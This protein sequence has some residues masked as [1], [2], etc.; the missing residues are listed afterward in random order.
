LT[1]FSILF[2]VAVWMG[3][4]HLFFKEGTMRRSYFV[5]LAVFATVGFSQARADFVPWSYNWEPSSLTIKAGGAGTGG[6]AL[7]DE[8]LKHADG[9]S[10]VVVTNIRA[11][12]SATR[13]NPDVLTHA[14]FSFKLVLRDEKSNQTAVL[15]FG[16]FFDG[17]ISATSAN[18]KATFTAPLF[19]T[20]KLGGHTFTI[21]LGNFAPPGPPAASNAGSIS[22]NV[23]VDQ[24]TSGGGTGG[25]TGGG[26]APEPSTLLLSCLGLSSLGLGG[27][28]KW[29]QKV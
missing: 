7:T 13:N 2:N 22:A 14:A 20:V 12:S 26:H 4:H 3:R 9:T 8:P 18:V 25:G 21:N 17:T 19:Q 27:W 6:L 11:F 10:D 28:R 16:G 15:S 23:A 5:A 1:Q 24:T 29:R